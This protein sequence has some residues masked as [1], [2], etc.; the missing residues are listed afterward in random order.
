MTLKAQPSARNPARERAL[1]GAAMIVGTSL[2]IQISAAIAHELF[3]RLGPAGASA[4]RFALGAL[5]L[6]AIVRPRITGRGVATWFAIVAYGASLA[7]LNITFFQA[8]S[9]IPMGIAVT[10]AF[11]APLVMALVGS[12]RP[13]DVVWA[14]LAGAG[15]ATLGGIDRPASIAGVVFAIA[16]GCAW[17]GV[18][19]AGRTIGRRTNRVDGLALAIPIA[20]V[21]AVPFGFGHLAAVDLRSLGIGLVIA[22]GGLI[23]PFALELEGLRRLEPRVVAVIYSIDP[24]IAAGVGL[25]ALGER[26]TVLQVAGI[27]A[28]MIASAGATV[29]A[30]RVASIPAPT[31]GSPAGSSILSAVTPTNSKASTP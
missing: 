7:A 17:V 12:R 1:A 25:L 13:R 5:I 2:T 8:I 18:A 30:G 24:A 20:A 10:F 26:L 22:V 9:R 29:G 14:L 27:V 6:V 3:A 21:V 28:V 4:I 15:V 19:Y 16:A 23:I 11:I 31:P